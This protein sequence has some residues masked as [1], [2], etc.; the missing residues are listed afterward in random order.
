[1]FTGPITAAVSAVLALAYNLYLIHHNLPATPKTE[2]LC[3]KLVKRLKDPE[4]FWGALYETYAFALFAV[5][6]FTMELEDE[7]D[8]SSKHCEF[9]A[10]SKS[11]RVYSVE[12]KARN[13][14]P[15][16]PTE[17]GALQIDE[18]TLRLG[19]KL[20]DALSKRALHERVVFLDIDM[21]GITREEQLQ[22]VSDFAVAR[23]RE[24]EGTMQIKGQPAPPAYVLVTNIP[25]HRNA[26]DFS[27]G[28]QIIGLGFKIDD[29]GQGVVHHGAHAMMRARERHA[30]ILSLRKAAGVRANVP[31]TFDGSNPALAFS[32]NTR[33]PLIIGQHYLVPTP[34]GEMEGVLV[35]GTVLPEKKMAYCAYQLQN[36]QNVIASNELTDDEVKAY[37]LHPGTFFGAVKKVA[38]KSETFEDLFDF[39]FESFQHTPRE[40]LLE[41][42]AGAPDLEELAK[43]SQRDLA[44]TYCERAAGHIA[45][46]FPKKA[47]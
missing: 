41:L 1:M 21:P 16:P 20:K 12:C 29:F 37:Q 23:F 45:A 6:G 44:I 25:D 34:D 17:D 15:A 30:D 28:L 39:F 35:E 18:Q 33:P 47:A 40:T 5:A 7:S 27:L 26:G 43:Q 46:K 9:T 36:G 32:E 3:K 14:A 4:H 10:R 24:L 22:Q 31:I 38:R 11:G 8:N 19:K 42:M 2:R 13:R